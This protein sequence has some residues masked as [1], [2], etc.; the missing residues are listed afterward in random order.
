MDQLFATFGHV[1]AGTK[2]LQED[3]QPLRR[4]ASRRQA[5]VTCCYQLQ[6]HDTQQAVFQNVCYSV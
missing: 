5:N 4:K 3:G 1:M 2:L 6:F